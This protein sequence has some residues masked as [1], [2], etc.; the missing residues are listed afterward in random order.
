ML[1]YEQQQ[2]FTSSDATQN[3][4][5]NQPL[6][7]ILINEFFSFVSC[8]PMGRILPSK[9]RIFPAKLARIQLFFFQLRTRTTKREYEF[10]R[11]VHDA[12]AR[13]IKGTP[14]QR[15]TKKLSGLGWGKQKTVFLSNG[16]L[17][18]AVLQRN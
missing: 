1:G 5:E 8:K 13:A 6:V 9:N 14:L 7:A 2:I 17:R 4:V 16:A 10:I 12:C 3:L 15:M 18:T 11:I